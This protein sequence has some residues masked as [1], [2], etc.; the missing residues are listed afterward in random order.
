MVSNENFNFKVTALFDSRSEKWVYFYLV[1]VLTLTPTAL[2]Y[3]LSDYGSFA[4]PLD[5]LLHQTGVNKLTLTSL[6]LHEECILGGVRQDR[7]SGRG[8]PEVV[9]TIKEGAS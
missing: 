1:V 2:H 5:L 9:P 8:K 3:Y 7:L 4:S 6:P